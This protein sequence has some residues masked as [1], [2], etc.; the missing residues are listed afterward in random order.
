MSQKKKYRKNEI[1]TRFQQKFAM[2]SYRVGIGCAWYSRKAGEI[3]SP[4]VQKKKLK[5]IKF[6]H[7]SCPINIRLVFGLKEF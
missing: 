3:C 1:Y 2:G 5:K 7:K 4:L 6:L